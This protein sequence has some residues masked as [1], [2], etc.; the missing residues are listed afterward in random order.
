MTDDFAELNELAIDLGNAAGRAVKDVN[1]A[2]RKSASDIERDA[3][4]FTPV[5]TGN[6]RNSISKTVSGLSAEI[7]PTAEYGVYV[8]FGTSTQG[9]AAFM[10]PAFDRNA[11][12]FETAVGIIGQRA[13]G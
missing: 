3:K 11:H 7:G 1:L 6:L 9:P 5:D 13:I 2:L 4:I 10:G 8:E 12:L